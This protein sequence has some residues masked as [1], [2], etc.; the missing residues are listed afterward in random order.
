[1][2]FIL[3]LFHFS[4]VFADVAPPPINC[5][6][7]SISSISGS[8]AQWCKS[9]DC[10]N[11]S[12]CLAIPLYFTSADYQCQEIAVCLEERTVTSLANAFKGTKSKNYDVVSVQGLCDDS[13]V[14]ERGECSV[15]KR[16]LPPTPITP[17][18]EPSILETVSVNNSSVPDEHGCRVASQADQRLLLMV[19][20]ILL[21]S[22]MREG[23]P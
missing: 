23:S 2:M 16:C 10:T 7:G 9:L 22:R 20:A 18:K 11:D 13:G 14:C 21:C 3:L 1:M 19:F 6:K 4:L 15:K 5:P 17:Q 8:S 12:D